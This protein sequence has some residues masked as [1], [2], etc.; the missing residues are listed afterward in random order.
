M[1][2]SVAGTSASRSTVTRR[3]AVSSLDEGAELASNPQ[4]FRR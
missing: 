3:R 2:L 1:F 4:P